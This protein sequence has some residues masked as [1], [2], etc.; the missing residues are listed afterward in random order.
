[1]CGIVGYVGFR[2]ASDVI[3]D[4]LSKLE[5][6]GYDSAGIAV[7]D[8]K[9]IEFQ[10]YKGRLNVLSENLES[11]PMEG[12][13]G[14]GHT[15]WATHG[16]PSDV[17]SHPH[18]NM[19]E[20]IAV[21]HN[22]IIENYMEIKDWLSS[23]GV[24]FKSETDTE[25]I[26]HLVDHYYEGDLL[27]AV[28]KAI[29]KL[30]GAYALGV[31]CKDNPEQLVA[32]RKDSPLIVGI[33]EN[34]NFIAS[35]VPA[36]LKYTRDVYFLDNGEV[37]TLEKDKIKI[38]NEKEEGITK[39]PFHVMWDVEAASKGGYDHFMIKEINEQPNGIKE[40]LVRR[41]DENG[42]IKL[43]DIK[44]TKEDLDEINKV[45][46]VACG[47]A[48]NAGI[49]GRYAI[50]RFAKIAVET[51]VASEF[52]YRNPFID[53]KTLIIVV[54]QSGE[55]ADTLA[56][57]REGKEK[58]ARV[59][60]IT[61]VVGSS[62]A[63]EADDV[64]YTWAGPEV[65]VA[66]TKAYTT[67]LVALYMIALDMGIKRGTITEEFYNDIISE[68]K[69]IPEKVQKIL[70]QHDDIKEIA[71]EI[72]DNEHAFYIGR[73]LDYNLSLEGSLKIKEIS[74]MHAEAFAAGELKHGT[75]ALIEENTP[76]V[77]TMT[78][79][80]LFEKSISNIKEV[81]SRGAHVIAITQEGNKE[82]EQVADKVI[83]I[84][85]TNDILQ[86]II[87]VVPHQLLAYYVAILKDRDVDKP[88]NLAK[89]VTVE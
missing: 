58:G 22:G 40:T 56:V 74:Y 38:Y 59:L 39:E 8:G 83:Y 64:F 17:N 49:T 67:Q 61:N 87:A 62:I 3:V 11:K 48:Y 26:A 73:G 44:L 79:T 70:Y 30:R 2:K 84:P 35:D 16:V 51:D 12:T 29:K 21:V 24:K 71:K 75:I 25:V 63:R 13:I 66:S 36:I 41:L 80:D 6:R 47:T 28:F 37:V 9:E 4:G 18:L 52:R 60:A 46:I 19:D 23:E 72:K 1:M 33:G 86:S 5:Y 32:V 27:Q 76:V 10:K 89:S 82:A 14:I 45:Y 53:D 7:N 50:E 15:R 55:T 68:L 85:R 43:D 34:E 20:T 42:K 31:V 81:K 77:A 88:R 65:A 57:V 69:L 78:Q 54:S